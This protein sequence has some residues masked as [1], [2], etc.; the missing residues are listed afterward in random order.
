MKKSFTL[1]DFFLLSHIETDEWLDQEVSKTDFASIGC[2][3]EIDGCGCKFEN[4][5]GKFVSP[6]KRITDNILG[7]ARALTVIKTKD[8]GCF[9]YILN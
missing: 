7:Y 8:C 4:Y 1:N 6:D 2:G 9:N 3:C 5:N